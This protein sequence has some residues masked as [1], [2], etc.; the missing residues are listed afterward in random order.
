MLKF[1]EYTKNLSF[2]SEPDYLRLHNY[3]STLA[4]KEGIDL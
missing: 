4:E 2:K 1:M 3:I